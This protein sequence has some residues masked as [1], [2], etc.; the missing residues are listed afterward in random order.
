MSGRPDFTISLATIGVGL[1]I[2]VPRVLNGLAD[3]RDWVYATAGL[4]IALIA[5]IFLA[6]TLLRK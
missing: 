4:G 2:G 3:T 6:V 5:A 1:A